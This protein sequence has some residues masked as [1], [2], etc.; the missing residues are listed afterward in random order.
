[1]KKVFVTSLGCK[2]N[3]YES[4]AFKCGFAE[5]GLSVV[6]ENEAADL[7]VI[8]TCAVT[9]GAGAQS[10][11]TIRQALRRNPTA[12]IVITGCYA[13]I[14]ARQLSEE[15]ELQG[16]R[17]LLIGNSKKD[18]LVASALEKGPYEQQ[19]LLGQINDAREI[20]RLPVRRFGERS[21]AYLRIQDGCES[22]CTYCIVPFTRGRSRSL[23]VIEVLEQAKIF[24]EEGH[25]EIVLTG[26]HL[27]YYGK[28][29]DETVD[30]LY[31]LDRLS[32]ATPETCYRIS[33]LEPV[34]ISEALLSL[35]ATRSN[36][37]PH[38][39]IPL[40][41]GCDDIL[42]KMNRRYTTDQFAEVIRL[43]RRFLPDA[44]IGIDILAGFPG[45]TDRHFNDAKEFL[46]TLPF[47]Y[48]HVFPYSIRPGT[49]AAGFKG[50]VPK[51]IKDARV[52]ELRALSEAKKQSFYQSQLAQVRPVLV[53][54]RRDKDGMLK[55]F[56]DNYIDVRLKGPDSLLD[57]TAL[58]R[59]LRLKDHCVLGERVEDHEN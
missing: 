15:K 1:M 34:E 44:A 32:L 26:I 19:I 10:R 23:P 27:G 38:L 40:Q 35:M 49:L 46:R 30:L 37:Q 9:A 53:E 50:Q 6:S 52:A 43:C 8:N 5:R 31:L 12:E 18:Q 2:V 58:V 11:Q 41:S 16:R 51:K 20:C 57:T 47:S 22:F 48:L 14:A 55:G 25:R 54:G 4:A 33:S 21:R 42:A 28:D 17:Y 13:E 36:I 59:L 39:H 56:T 45:E 7:V 29:L 3:Q 24:A